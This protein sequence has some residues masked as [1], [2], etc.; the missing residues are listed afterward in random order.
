[1]VT[2]MPI[3]TLRIN[4][5]IL[6]NNNTYRVRFSYSYRQGNKF[7]TGPKALEDAHKKKII[8]GCEI[9]QLNGGK[10]ET[11][12]TGS[13]IRKLEDQF[14][15]ATGRRNSLGKCTRTLPDKNLRKM[16]WATYFDLH[17][18]EVHYVV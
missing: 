16:I 8:T 14:I 3:G 10:W 5:N 13:S 1:M 2:H 18:K 12:S 4:M 15:K 11:I 9:Q 17:K 7:I 6:F